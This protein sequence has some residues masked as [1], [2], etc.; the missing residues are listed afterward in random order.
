MLAQLF[1]TPS[2]ITLDVIFAAAAAVVDAASE[3]VAPHVS[4]GL[5][6][7]TESEPSLFF[8][9]ASH[10]EDSSVGTDRSEIS[11]VRVPFACTD[12]APLPL[13]PRPRSVPRPR[14]RPPSWE[15]RPPLDAR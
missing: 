7:S 11:F 12:A 3:A 10:A 2:G 5:A 1:L 4:A 15:E 9:V 6:L 13:P 14:P 8:G